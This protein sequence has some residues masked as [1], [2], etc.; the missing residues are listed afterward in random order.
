M[1]KGI[2]KIIVVIVLLFVSQFSFAQQ[3]SFT[4]SG[5]IKGL[6]SKYMHI[7]F[8]DETG[9]RRDSI[10]VINESF[11]Y[12]TSIKEMTMISISPGVEAVMKR[13]GRG[14]FPAKSSLL[15]FV[16]TPGADIKFS[17]KI[18]DFVD[19]YPKG[20]EANK[21]LAK[22]NKSVFPL[23]NKSV[24]LS[25]KIANKVVTDSIAIK[26]MEK[27][28]KVLDE[29]VITIKE[30]FIQDNPSSA[31]SAWLLADMMLRSQVSNEKA[32]A[33]FS[34]INKEKL[35]GTSFYIEAAKRVDGISAT[36]VGKQVPAIISGNTYDGKNFDL[37]SLKGKYVVIDFW[38]TWCG[39]CIAGMPKMKEYLD[40]YQTK[41]EIVGVASESD[42]GTRWKKFITD[43]PEYNWHHVLSRKDKDYILKFSV[44]GFPTK[45]I[46]D[47]TGKI[48]GRFVGETE[49]IYTKLDELLK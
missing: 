42:D 28:G 15:Q 23:M 25:L 11:S 35:V 3:N 10:A 19:A 6:D 26:E 49:E 4:V 36:A 24:N 22:L 1:K 2:I 18:T 21:S 32:T 33:L 17:G 45:I 16:A 7:V 13:T 38:G 43:N 34:K 40:K 14:Y 20:D 27:T 37:A 48:V 9:T 30:K 46:V 12:T 31:T 44:A 41:M 5:K 29:K 47:P 39:P 8:K